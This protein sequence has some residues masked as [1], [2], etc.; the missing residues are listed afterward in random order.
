[1]KPAPK[2]FPRVS[3]SLW[4][5]DAGR[6]IDWLCEAFGFE[7]RLRIEGDAGRIEHSELIF[8]EGL[9]M[10]GSEGGHAASDPGAPRRVSPASLDG[11][12]TQCVCVYVDDAAAHCERARRAG[13]KILTEPKVSDYGEE[14]WSDK[15]YACEDLEGH[16]WWFVERVRDVKG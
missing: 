1:M 9:I 4:Y 3:S 15:G 12:N 13:A 14:Y 5:R 7:V 16:M 11:A 10:V 2:N 6:A 8:G